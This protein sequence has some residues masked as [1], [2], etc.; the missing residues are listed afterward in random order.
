VQAQFA[1]LFSSGQ[2][3]LDNS[4]QAS[5]PMQAQQSSS[6]HQNPFQISQMPSMMSPSFSGQNNQMPN[7]FPAN[8]VF[9]SSSSNHFGTGQQVVMPKMPFTP[10]GGRPSLG[11]AN[12]F[13]VVLQSQVQQPQ[14]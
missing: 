1:D 3:S 9:S 6:G 10:S 7:C 13:D 8:D 5:C 4:Y 11:G 2:Q 12:P 14:R